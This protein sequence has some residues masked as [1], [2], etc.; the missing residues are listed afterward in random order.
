MLVSSFTYSQPNKVPPFQIIQASGKAFLAGN[1]PLGEPIVI[2]YFSPECDECQQLTKELL[3]RIKE[4]KN[5]SI[6]MITN[7]S[8]DK[9]KQFVTEYHLDKYPNI[10]VGTEGDTFF[11]G[12]YYR[13]GKLPFMALYTKNGDLIKIYD[14]VL[15]IDDLIINLRKL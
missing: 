2:I 14:K 5:T 10:F 1:L 8:L 13:V 11:V 4:F 15:S 9:V 7:L 3:N 12:K 6:A